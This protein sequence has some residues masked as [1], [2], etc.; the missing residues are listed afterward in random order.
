IPSDGHVVS[1]RQRVRAATGKVDRPATTCVDGVHRRDQ[2]GAIAAGHVHRC[3]CTCCCRGDQGGCR[4]ANP[5][6][7][8]TPQMSEHTLKHLEAP[9]QGVSADE[10]ELG[11]RNRPPTCLIVPLPNAFSNSTLAWASVPE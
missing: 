10:N 4:G 6:D 5:H 7:A 9:F 11:D 1:R 3:C 8:E 2:S